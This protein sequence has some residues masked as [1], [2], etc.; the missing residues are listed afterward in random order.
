MSERPPC[1]HCGNAG[2][3]AVPVGPRDL[4]GVQ[5]VEYEACPVCRAERGVG[6]V[7][8]TPLDFESVG[9]SERTG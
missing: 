2:E 5:H 4:F 7:E 1:Y 6:Y 3:V 8:V 9:L